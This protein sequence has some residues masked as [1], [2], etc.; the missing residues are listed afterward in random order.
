MNILVSEVERAYIAGFFDGE[1]SVS[2]CYRRTNKGYPQ[3]AF[4][5]TITNTRRDVLEWIRL[6]YSGVIVQVRN[7]PKSN[8]KP[9]FSLRIYRGAE[10]IL[11]DIYPFVRL[12]KRQVEI[13]LEIRALILAKNRKNERGHPIAESNILRRKELLAELKLLNRRGFST[14]NHKEPIP[15]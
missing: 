13:G 3:W 7:A 15:A 11:S 5:I 6:L 10:T 1:G 2:F 12:K 4:C 9:C 8:Q 14:E